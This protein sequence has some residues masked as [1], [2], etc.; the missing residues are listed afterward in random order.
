MTTIETLTAEVHVVT[1]NG[2]H[3]TIGQARQLDRLT[4][5]DY[6][7][8]CITPLGRVRTGIT[9]ETVEALSKRPD[10]VDPTRHISMVGSGDP[11]TILWWEQRKT[12]PWLEVL[13]RCRDDGELVIFTIASRRS[14]LEW[15]AS[16]RQSADT[17]ESWE[18][19]PLILLA[20]R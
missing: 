7:P 9:V 6:L 15:L 8:E 17:F 18:D 10:H 4:H 2:Q 5:L 13:G 16:D 20:D 19:L 12:T 3:L 11:V 1:I 14:M